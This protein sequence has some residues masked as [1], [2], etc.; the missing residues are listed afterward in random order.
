MYTT[1]A[2]FALYLQKNKICHEREVS[3]EVNAIAV[4]NYFIGLAGSENVEIRQFGLMKR[5]YITHG[6]CLALLDR[7]AL[8]PRFDVVEAW[9]NGPVIPS[10][11]HSFKY[12]GNNPIRVKSLIVEV[13]DNELDF[14]TP[15]LEDNEIQSIAQ[16][17]WKRYLGMDD[18]ELIKLLHKDGTPWSRCYEEG[19]NNRID[20]L[21]TKA[22][23][24]KLI[25]YEVSRSRHS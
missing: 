6:F 24:K 17:V 7:S 15:E 14:K 21:Y 2:Y 1:S 20:D 4:A 23:Y 16:A 18:F 9:K 10:V 25:E 11:Y 3:M 12:N 13:G 22:Y 5:V 8:D 19:K